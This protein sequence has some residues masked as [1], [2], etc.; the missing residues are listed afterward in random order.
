[1][2]I[3][4]RSTIVTISGGEGRNDMTEVQMQAPIERLGRALER[5]AKGALALTLYGSG[6]LVVS[7]ILFYFS[8]KLGL[9]ALLVLTGLL[10]LGASAYLLWRLLRR[11][12][13]RRLWRYKSREAAILRL[14]QRSRGRL[15][16]TEVAMG[17]G[18]TLREAE[19]TL[20]EL[21]R[22]GYVDLEVS[23]SGMLV[24]HCVPLSGRDDRDSAEQVL[25]H[26]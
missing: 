7:G 24:Y 17:T 18:L 8:W 3:W 20:R 12:Q 22:E 1:M 6:S 26:R 16:V 13:P 5:L 9:S 4:K 11:G 19:A 21:V 2:V 10:P 23:P 25:P 14:A 15:T